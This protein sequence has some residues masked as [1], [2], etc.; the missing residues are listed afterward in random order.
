MTS[1]RNLKTML[2]IRMRKLGLLCTPTRIRPT[3]IRIS[4]TI[5]PDG[6]ITKHTRLTEKPLFEGNTLETE[7]HIWNEIHKQNKIHEV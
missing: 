5:N 7:L 3:R 6:S 4:Q 2:L 1:K